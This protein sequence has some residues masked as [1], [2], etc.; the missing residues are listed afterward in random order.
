DRIGGFG[1][2]NQNQMFGQRAKDQPFERLDLLAKLSRPPRVT[3]NDLAA[4]ANESEIPKSTFDVLDFGLVVNY[5]RVTESSVI[6]SFTVQ[7]ENQELVY[8]ELGVAP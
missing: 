5:L 1:G 8:K 4:L 6:T 2:N 7:L 3:F